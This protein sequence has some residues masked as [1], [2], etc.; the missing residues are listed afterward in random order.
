MRKSPFPSSDPRRPCAGVEEKLPTLA[1][2][3][4]ETRAGGAFRHGGRRSKRLPHGGGVSRHA[5]DRPI[6]GDQ[7]GQRRLPPVLPHGRF[8]RAV[9]RGCGDRLARARHRA[10]QARQAFGRGHSHVRRAGP[11]R[12]RLSPA[13]DRHRPAASRSASRSRTPPRP[14]SADPRRWSAATWCASS[15][16]ARSPRRRCS[17]P[18]PTISSPHCSARRPKDGSRAGL[19]ACLARYFHRRADRLVGQRER[20]CRR[21]C[22]AQARRGAGRRRSC[23][24]CGAPPPDRGGS[25]PL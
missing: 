17:M 9:L 8:L 4:T 22:Q 19:C 15:R 25:A 11:C 21:A 20:S 3:E 10:D 6:S 16:R 7:G 13:P 18:A 2:A 14:E 1:M 5:H 23:R 12:R 24:R